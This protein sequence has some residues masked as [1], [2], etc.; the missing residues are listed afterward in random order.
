MTLTK[1]QFDKISKHLPVQRKKATIDNHTFLNAILYIIENG[2]KWRALPKEFGDWHVIYVRFN[3]WSKDGK[4][5]RLFAALQKEGIISIDMK[6]VCID[7]TSV[8][9][10]PDG[11]GALKKVE[12]KALGVLKEDSP[13]KFIWCPL[14]QKQR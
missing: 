14:L 1:K 9:V 5:E 11:S 8:K 6:V 7:S 4:L 10:H 3:R 13:L 12:S 2:C